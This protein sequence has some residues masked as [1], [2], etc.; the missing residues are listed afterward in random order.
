MVMEDIETIK[1]CQIVEG[2]SAIDGGAKL[3]QVV[4]DRINRDGF[5]RVSFA[6]LRGLPSSFYNVLLMQVL[7]KSGGRELDTIV[8]FEFDSSPQREIFQR[9]RDRVIQTMR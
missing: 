1:A 2:G 5:A 6:G 8:E 9:S 4:I 3:A 7:E